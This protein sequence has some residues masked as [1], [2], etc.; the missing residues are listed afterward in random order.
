MGQ[1]DVSELLIDSD[2]TEDGPIQVISRAYEVNEK[3]RNELTETSRDVIAVVQPASGNTLKRLPD[4]AQLSKWCTVY[5]QE[6]LVEADEGRYA[7]IVVW[8]GRRYQV[9]IVAD[10]SNWGAGWTRADCLLEGVES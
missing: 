2:F 10:Y 4:G 1:I 7:D 3:G 6:T 8:N 9:Q 5:T